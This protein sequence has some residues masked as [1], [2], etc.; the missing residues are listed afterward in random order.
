[1][2]RARGVAVLASKSRASSSCPWLEAIRVDVPNSVTTPCYE[3]DHRSL[4]GDPPRA[5]G[6]RVKGS[7]EARVAREGGPHVG[8]SMP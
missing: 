2:Q 1:M 3:S 5:G 6:A 4:A 7:V 8:R